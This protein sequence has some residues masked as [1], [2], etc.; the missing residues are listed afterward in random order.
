M[1]K[2][3]VDFREQRQ[4]DYS[5][6]LGLKYHDDVTK[7]QF[8]ELLRYLE[9]KDGGVYAALCA[10][11]IR[12][13]VVDIVCHASNIINYLLLNNEYSQ[14]ERKL[15]MEKISVRKCDLSSDKKVYSIMRE[16]VNHF[17]DLDAALRP[18]FGKGHP[19]V[20]KKSITF[21]AYVGND[22]VGVAQL[23]KA[24]W[25]APVAFLSNLYVLRDFRRRGVGSALAEA[26]LTEC[27]RNSW[28]VQYG[29][30]GMDFEAMTFWESVR[31]NSNVLWHTYYIRAKDIRWMM[32]P[33]WAGKGADV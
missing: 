9:E 14:E 24:G 11:E 27:A 10:D 4:S 7:D 33:C 28:A 25:G 13:E 1:T 31:P 12:H 30:I 8:N 16:A 21:A 32:S 15:Q 20:D 29:V 19:K 23:R 22:P 17:A 2:K 26:A 6:M 18:E 3:D 5:T